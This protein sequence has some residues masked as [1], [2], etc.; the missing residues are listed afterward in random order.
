MSTEQTPSRGTVIQQVRPSVITADISNLIV[1]R[2]R[3]RPFTLPDGT[4]VARIMFNSNYVDYIVSN[5]NENEL[6][7][8]SF[9]ESVRGDVTSL[10]TY[11]LALKLALKCNLFLTVTYVNILEVI[12]EFGYKIHITSIR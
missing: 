12:M 2:K 11:E 3:P 10:L 9:L 7:I 1:R 5:K 4:S 8:A 6:I